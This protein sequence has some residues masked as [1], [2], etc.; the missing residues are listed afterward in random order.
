[1]VILKIGKKR[2]GR[3]L[4]DYSKIRKKGSG[5]NPEISPGVQVQAKTPLLPSKIDLLKRA[6]VAKPLQE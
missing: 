4:N 2:P 6:E 5:L 3:G 1:M